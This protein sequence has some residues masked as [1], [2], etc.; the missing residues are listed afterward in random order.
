MTPTH[1]YANYHNGTNVRPY[2]VIHQH[3]PRVITVRSMLFEKSGK[4]YIIKPDLNGVT[5]EI[6]QD[7]D[8]EWYFGSSR[9][10]LAEAPEVKELITFR[11]LK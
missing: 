5:F 11:F 7:D 3:R 1:S 8:E 9:F 4:D 10:V 2:E 6:R